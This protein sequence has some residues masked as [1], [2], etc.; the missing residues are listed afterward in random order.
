[1]KV[2]RVGRVEDLIDAASGNTDEAR[3]IL[4]D[5][6][7]YNFGH[8]FLPWQKNV[9]FQSISPIRN[10]TFVFSGFLNASGPSPVC[11]INALPGG[12]T[13]KIFGIDI[14]VS[15][16]MN[17]DGKP[18]ICAPIGVCDGGFSEFGHIIIENVN[19]DAWSDALYLDDSMCSFGMRNCSI[20][21]R[22]DSL[23]Y[24]SGRV[25][26]T[27]E[28]CNI[29]CQ[30]PEGIA[31]GYNA[32]T[33]GQVYGAGTRIMVQKSDCVVAGN[34]DSKFLGVIEGTDASVDFGPSCKV[35]VPW[36]SKFQSA[37]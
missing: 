36:K 29:T 20:N 21:T 14:H 26:G 6:G 27:I 32:D 3:M 25:Y 12:G 37:D 17:D 23:G 13:R 10:P 33:W 7:I 19:I 35:V 28:K 18:R 24:Y 31:V 4:V 16:Y 8:Q 15:K 1:M 2:F 5:D 34:V 30:R 11:C 22:W 9:T